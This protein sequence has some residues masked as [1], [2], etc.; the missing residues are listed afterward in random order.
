MENKA[1]I[2]SLKLSGI[3]THYVPPSCKHYTNIFPP[4]Y[5]Y[6]FCMQLKGSWNK[7]GFGE[8]SRGSF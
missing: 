8:K 2:Q 5:L 1:D 3:A 7:R 6:S 4:I